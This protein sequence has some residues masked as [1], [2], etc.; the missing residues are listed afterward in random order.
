MNILEMKCLIS[1]VGVSRMDSVRNEEVLRRAGIE[2][3]WYGQVGRIDE[4]L[5]AKRVL[6]ADV[7]GGQ[8]RGR[9][10]LGLINGV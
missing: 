1:L 7:S 9:P 8:E 6:M 3:G 5:M 2:R 10:R 4:Y